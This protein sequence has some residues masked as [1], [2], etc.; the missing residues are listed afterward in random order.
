MIDPTSNCRTA[1]RI[2]RDKIKLISLNWP[3]EESLNQSTLQ[4]MYCYSNRLIVIDCKRQLCLEMKWI[5][6]CDVHLNRPGR[7]NHG[8]YLTGVFKG[9]VE[10]DL[11]EAERVGSYSKSRSA[12]T[13]ILGY[14]SCALPSNE[15]KGIPI[16]T[17]LSLHFESCIVCLCQRTPEQRYDI[18]IH[19][20]K[21]VIQ[22]DRSNW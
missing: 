19:F 6:I 14:L 17:V 5:G 8:R 7:T 3:A 18:S 1:S 12:V 15:A 16:A 22:F 11:L 13:V 10:V 21:E 4:I 2:P 20:G 9:P